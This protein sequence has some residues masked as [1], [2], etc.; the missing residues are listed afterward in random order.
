M[1]MVSVTMVST[2]T[3]PAVTMATV[4]IR[5]GHHPWPWSAFPSKPEAVAS[6]QNLQR[7]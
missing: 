7:S 1:T 3:M 6:K 4:T 2:V 5:A